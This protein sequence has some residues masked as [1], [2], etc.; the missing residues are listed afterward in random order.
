MGAACRQFHGTGAQIIVAHE[1]TQC[2]SDQGRLVP[3][4]EAIENNLGRKPEQAS[5][6]SGYC[7]EANLEALEAHGIDGYVAPGPAKHLD[8]PSTWTRQAPDRRKRENLRTADP[9]DAKK[10]RRRRLRNSLPIEKASGGTGV[11]TDQTGAGLPPVPIAGRRKSACRVGHDL[12]RRQ[13]PEAVHPPKRCL[14]RLLCNK[15]QARCLSRQAPGLLSPARRARPRSP[16]VPQP[17]PARSGPTAGVNRWP[18]EP[19]PVSRVGRSGPGK[20]KTWFGYQGSGFKRGRAGR[21]SD[22][23][24]SSVRSR[25]SRHI[26]VPVALVADFLG[27]TR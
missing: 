23:W 8:P 11:R 17:S 9:T 18:A 10:D 22:S 19:R 20:P 24:L 16:P 2:G 27:A 25:A 6:D 13:P 21:V 7:S 5:A 12:H 14:S 1:L 3:L 4:V 26:R 15:C